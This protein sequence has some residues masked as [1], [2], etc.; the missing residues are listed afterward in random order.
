MKKEEKRLGK[1]TKIPT[2]TEQKMQEILEEVDYLRNKIE[3]LEYENQNLNFM[4]EKYM[5]YFL[6]K[7]KNKTK[8]K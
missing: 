3:E 7:T 4:V 6:N 8:T 1:Y 2:I 5:D